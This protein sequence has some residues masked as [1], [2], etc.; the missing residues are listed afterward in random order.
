MDQKTKL[1]FDLQQIKNIYNLLEDGPYSD[2]FTSHL[3]SIECE[4]KRQLCCLTNTNH[5]TKIKESNTN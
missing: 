3:L 2:F 4:I 5:Y 1:F